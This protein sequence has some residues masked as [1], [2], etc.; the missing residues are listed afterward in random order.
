M[1]QRV[2]SSATKSR[3]RSDC[4]RKRNGWRVRSF[5]SSCGRRESRRRP[6][7]AEAMI[8][9]LSI[10]QKCR[11]RTGVLIAALVFVLTMAAALLA[12]EHSTPPASKTQ[13]GS[14][15][16]LPPSEKKRGADYDVD[17]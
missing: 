17:Q 6:W 1:K 11:A 13:K 2:R 4:R 5:E 7:R 15:Q 12:Q 16:P 3:R 10:R 9:A 8:K 14:S